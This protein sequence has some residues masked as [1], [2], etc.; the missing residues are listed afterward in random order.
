MLRLSRE[1][2]VWPDIG[3]NIVSGQAVSHTRKEATKGEIDNDDKSFDDRY[4]NIENTLIL[5]QILVSKL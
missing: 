1:V 3:V 4:T 5:S 2:R